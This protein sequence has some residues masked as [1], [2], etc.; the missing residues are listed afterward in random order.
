MAGIWDESATEN[1]FRSN[2]DGND[3][4]FN[5]IDL[6]IAGLSLNSTPT[7][8]FESKADHSNTYMMGGSDSFLADSS[9]D[10]TVFD[11]EKLLK[12]QYIEF[13]DYDVPQ[14]L[15]LLVTLP[16]L[17]PHIT[18]YPAA[19]LFQCIRYAD[20]EKGSP[21]LVESLINLSL[22]KI[23]SSVAINGSAVLESTT[24]L[25]SGTQSSPSGDIVTQSYWF[26]ALSFLHYYLCKD[27][28]FY[29]RYP[30]T[31]QEIID[32]LHSIM[33][34]LISSIHSRL[35]PLIYPT[36]LEY[37][38]IE[39]VKQTL[40][41]NDWNFFKKRRQA[42]AAQLASEK[43]KEK[44]GTT[45]YDDEMLRHLYPPSLE[46]QM[47][48]SPMKIVQIFGALVYVL[49]LHQTHPL[50]QQQCLSMAIQWFSTTLFNQIMKDRS[51]K[52]LSRA[53]AI[54]IRLNLDTLETWIKN[55]DLVVPKPI[56]IDDFMWQL[57]PYTLIKDVAEIN[58]K[59]PTLRNIA[60]YRAIHNDGR[61]S[62]TKEQKETDEQ[63]NWVYDTTNSAFYYQSFHRIAQIHMEPV[64]QLLQWLQVATTLGDEEELD[65]TVYLL[66]RLTPVQLLKSIDHYSYELEEHKFKSALKKKLSTL[67]KSEKRK[68]DIYVQERQ[69]TLLALPTIAELTDSYSRNRENSKAFQPFLPVD[70][71][72]TAFDIHD[73]NFRARRDQIYY[74]ELDDK[75]EYEDNAKYQ[76]NH[77]A[78]DE[79][80]KEGINKDSRKDFDDE[81]DNNDRQTSGKE[82]KNGEE[83]VLN[84]KSTVTDN[85]LNDATNNDQH[86]WESKEFESNPW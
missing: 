26:G 80:E 65:A 68:N 33:I 78:E 21:S 37:T 36:I 51:K 13:S 2:N 72:D 28:S 31:L 23:L 61:K 11:F 44:G 56:L 3:P 42:K 43:N 18:T 15:D 60:L 40:Y 38:T 57:F 24:N 83:D 9:G 16:K 30:G 67:S 20:H 5:G 50:Y 82:N 12:Y 54:Q 81:A 77:K 7:D 84:W 10:G 4:A 69:L 70:V 49:D 32:G 46:E 58:L 73:K 41:K 62:K 8:T 59:Y 75:D 17:H 85:G 53:H 19:L 48:P 14:L 39:D 34:Q 6:R 55:N 35:S 64:Y 74:D 79:D 45:Y 1:G 66:Q 25:Q 76:D 27:E 22:T 63:R 52:S 71:E 29:K 86:K 47:K